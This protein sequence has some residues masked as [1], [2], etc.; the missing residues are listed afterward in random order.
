VLIFVFM[1]VWVTLT[2]CRGGLGS[3]TGQGCV[4]KAVLP[5]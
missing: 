5:I 1:T 2:R 4:Y 3:R